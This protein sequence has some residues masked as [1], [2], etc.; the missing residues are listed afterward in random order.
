MKKNAKALE[1]RCV[2][3]CFHYSNLTPL[4]FSFGFIICRAI[5]LVAKTHLLSFLAN[6]KAKTEH[7]P[8]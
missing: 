3:T 6:S 4:N 5:C 1:D 7:Q 2:L 8:E